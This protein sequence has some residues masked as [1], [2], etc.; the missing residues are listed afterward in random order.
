MPQ[1]I[2]PQ[3]EPIQLDPDRNRSV[4]YQGREYTHIAPGTSQWT[5]YEPLAI[6]IPTVFVVLVGLWACTFNIHDV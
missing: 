5:G 2:R 4:V 1:P 3:D 6:L